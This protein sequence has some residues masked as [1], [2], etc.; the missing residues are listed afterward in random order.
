MLTIRHQMVT[1]D[2]A[3]L[4]AELVRAAGSTAHVARRPPVNRV[5][6]QFRLTPLAATTKSIIIVGLKLRMPIALPVILVLEAH[7][8]LIPEAFAHPT[9]SAI[10][11]LVDPNLL[12]VDLNRIETR[13]EL[14]HR[15]LRIS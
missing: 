6:A 13:L 15:L 8:S 2:A 5:S 11:H 1:V 9:P 3:P 14:G 10:I 7:V 12:L 4:S